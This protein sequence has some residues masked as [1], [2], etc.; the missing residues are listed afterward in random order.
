MNF[1]N[2]LQDYYS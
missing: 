2:N 1:N